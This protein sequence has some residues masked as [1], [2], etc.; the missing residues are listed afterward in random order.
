MT[1]LVSSVGTIMQGFLSKGNKKETNEEFDKLK[2]KFT[3]Y[4]GKVDEAVTNAIAEMKT[5]VDKSQFSLT[6][7]F[8]EV[9]NLKDT[10]DKRE[11]EL[12]KQQVDVSGKVNVDF[13]SS[14]NAFAGLTKNQIEDLM[15]SPAFQEAL[16]KI[17]KENWSKMHL[18]KQ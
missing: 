17:V 7:K 3:H 16:T 6:D 11:S 5:K 8:Y 12:K 4:G 18:P 10:K 1:Q 14:T 13:T 2:A 15:K 9:T